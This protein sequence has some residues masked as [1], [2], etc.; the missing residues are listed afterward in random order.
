M[1]IL[2]AR[3]AGVINICTHDALMFVFCYIQCLPP[4]MDVRACVRVRVSVDQALMLMHFVQLI[5]TACFSR[6]P[7]VFVCTPSSIPPLPCMGQKSL[8]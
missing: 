3:A 2:L 8:V 1:K 6:K 4:E 5:N 7:P